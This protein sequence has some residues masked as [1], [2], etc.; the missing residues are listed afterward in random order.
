MVGDD[1][2]DVWLKDVATVLLVSVFSSLAPSGDDL[3][4]AMVAT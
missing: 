3:E 1:T 4:A 2:D